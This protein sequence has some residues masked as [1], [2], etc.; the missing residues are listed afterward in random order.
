MKKILY[1]RIAKKAF[2]QNE[3]VITIRIS[4]LLSFVKKKE[5]Y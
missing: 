1:A 5:I 3:L 2:L 4:P